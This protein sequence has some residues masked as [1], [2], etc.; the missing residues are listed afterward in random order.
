MGAPFSPFSSRHS[1]DGCGTL[2][3][4]VTNPVDSYQQGRMDAFNIFGIACNVDTWHEIGQAL[5][6]MRIS[7]FHYICWRMCQI[8]A[9]HDDKDQQ[10]VAWQARSLQAPAQEG[11]W[12]APCL[13]LA[14]ISILLQHG[15]GHRTFD[16]PSRSRYWVLSWG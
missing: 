4:H 11:N 3:R 5:L 15:K 2:F 10:I 1:C 9:D 14:L 8:L 7:S 16:K 12:T 13:F 6:M